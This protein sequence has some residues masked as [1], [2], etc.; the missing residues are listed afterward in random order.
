MIARFHQQ[1]Q[2][3]VIETVQEISNRPTEPTAK[4]EYLVALATYLGVRW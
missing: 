4:P 2:R 3:L 1:Y